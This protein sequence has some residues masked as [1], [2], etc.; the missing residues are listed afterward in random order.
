MTSH[1]S[2]IN[3]HEARAIDRLITQYKSKE[4][5]EGLVKAFT[6]QLQL[7]ENVGAD[8]VNKRSIFDAAG[9]ELDRWGNLLVEPRFG[10]ND[11]DYRIQLIAKVA[12]NFSEGTAEDLISM[13][14][15]LTRAAYIIY[16]EIYPAEVSITAVDVDLIGD[17]NRIR[18][19]L[20]LAKAAG[21]KI[22]SAIVTAANVFSFDGDTDPNSLGFGDVN[23]L[24]LGGQWASII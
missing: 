12:Q 24:N 13:F 3:D 21:V 10:L 16:S 15:S 19:V 22:T 14:K 20:D 6:N 7:I 4:K 8:L 17:S 23:D 5:I 18:S 11:S 2:I 9:I 1:I